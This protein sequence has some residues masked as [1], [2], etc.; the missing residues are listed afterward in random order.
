MK[1]V[2]AVI[3]LFVFAIVGC[4]DSSDLS[5]DHIVFIVGEGEY[6]ANKTM[7]PVAKELEE[8]YGFKV[9]YLEAPRQGDIP[10]L[11]IIKD[12]DLLVLYIRFRQPSDEQL[13]LLQDY[14]DSGKPAVA[15]RT[16]SHAFWGFETKKTLDDVDDFHELNIIDGDM[17]PER[18]GWFP[19]IFGGNY[20]THPDH[21]DGMKTVIPAEASDHPILKGVPGF[22]AW[23][24]GGTYISEPLAETTEVL[25]LGKTGDLQA[26]PVAWTNEYKPGSRLFYTSLGTPAHFKDKEFLNLLYNSIFWALD[27]NIP[28]GGVLKLNS[29]RGVLDNKNE[30]HPSPPKIDTPANAKIL[31]DGK[32]VDMWKHYDRGMEPFSIDIDDR[33]V[34][35]VGSPKYLKP[36]W[37]I[38]NSSLVAFPGQGDIVTKENY[39]N[40][41]LHLNFLIP[42]EPD[43][44]QNGFRGSGG[45]YLSGRY[46]VQILDSFGE[47]LNKTSMGAIYGVNAPDIN[48]AKSA[49]EWQSLTIEYKH[50][51]DQSAEI[52]VWLNGQKIQQNVKVKEPTQNGFFGE[53][54][55]KGDSHIGP[56]RLQSDASRIRYANIWL[57]SL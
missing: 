29:S 26:D 31:F 10:N 27:K 19:P 35:R 46:E 41:K 48:A 52:S 21:K 42:K 12:A 24:F 20:L 22:R 50:P 34:S 44:Y 40:Y 53:P 17:I 51:K 16:T 8:N 3:S 25:M 37:Q 56:I 45:V 6:S 54:E 39:T 28:E 32:S 23:G 57:E 38:D 55:I 43:Y 7:P 47:E 1:K 36:R 4:S 2:F 30:N 49:G 18:L 13:K 15:L 11:E 9:T 5:S 33:A 14:F